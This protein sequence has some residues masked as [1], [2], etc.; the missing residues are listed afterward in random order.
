MRKWLVTA[1]APFAGATTN[2][3]QIIWEEL[4]RR[5]WGGRLI[6]Y[7]PLPVEF[8]GAWRA[9]QAGFDAN[10][11]VDNCLMLGQAEGRAKI[12]LELLALNW[13]DASIPDNAGVKPKLGQIEAGVGDH[14]W[15][16]IPW[17]TYE[18][19]KGA[20]Q[21]S[22][23]AGTYVCNELLFRALRAGGRH[24]GFV[25]IPWLD[26]QG[27]SL[28]PSMKFDVAMAEMENIL[29]FALELD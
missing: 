23:S 13:I 17:L 20:S 26:L 6:F 7:G 25:H 28:G 10:P 4:A 9:L 15:S 29:R 22:Y 27:P 1:F 3:S 11:G 18:S 8:G 2:S 24:R 12:G 19:R 5:E 21:R 16:S 14:L